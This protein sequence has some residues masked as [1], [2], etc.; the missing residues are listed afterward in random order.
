MKQK[1]KEQKNKTIEESLTSFD[2][3]LIVLTIVALALIMYG[4]TTLLPVDTSVRYDLS[5]FT[6]LLVK[7]NRDCGSTNFVNNLFNTGSEW[8][9]RVNTC[10]DDVCAIKYIKLSDCLK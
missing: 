8:A 7:I 6:E 2:G 10:V 4:V 5:N 9:V 1:T 3:F